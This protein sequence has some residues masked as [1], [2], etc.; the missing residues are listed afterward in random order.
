[1]HHKRSIRRERERGR[2]RESE[3]GRS[4]P[5]IYG[6]IVAVVGFINFNVALMTRLHRLNKISS[7]L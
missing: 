1:M 7:S 3:R 2:E 5:H 4:A 6:C